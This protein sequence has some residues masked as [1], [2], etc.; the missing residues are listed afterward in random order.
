LEHGSFQKL[1]SQSA[2]VAFDERRVRGLSTWSN[3]AYSN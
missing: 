3:T 1:P 2:Q